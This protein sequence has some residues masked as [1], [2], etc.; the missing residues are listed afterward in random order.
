MSQV[1]VSESLNEQEII[2]SDKGEIIYVDPKKKDEI[3]DDASGEISSE[4]KV[5]DLV[6]DIVNDNTQKIS[7]Q[8]D[9]D[10]VVK[11]IKTDENSH[12]IELIDSAVMTLDMLK[13]EKFDDIERK[14]IVMSAFTNMSHDK[15]ILVNNPKYALFVKAKFHEYIKD[16]GYDFLILLYNRTFSDGSFT[17]RPAI[18]PYVPQEYIDKTIK[19]YKDRILDESKPIKLCKFSKGEIVGARDKERRW[20][21]SRILLISE[22]KPTQAYIYYVE[23][24]G[25]GDAFNEAITDPARIERFNPFKHKYYRV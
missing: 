17:E 2:I 14:M 25:W 3:S 8:F 11:T 15:K 20:W 24:L 6:K 9:L 21:M 1:N 16:Y 7:R 12:D 18:I 23:F 13:N 19:Y 4:I 22:Y 5:N 10:D